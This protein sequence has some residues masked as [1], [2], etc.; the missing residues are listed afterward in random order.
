MVCKRI[1]IIIIII[2]LLDA[3]LGPTVFESLQGFLRLLLCLY[4]KEKL[5]FSSC[6]ITRTQARAR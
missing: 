2:I 4:A 1:I 5:V 6:A 3:A